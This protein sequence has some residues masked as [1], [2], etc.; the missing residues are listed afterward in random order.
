MNN[1]VT[2]KPPNPPSFVRSLAGLFISKDNPHGITPKE[3]KV[4]DLLYSIVGK[5]K[6]TNK[7]KEIIS[8]KLNQGFQVTVNYVNKLKRKRVITKD[9][10]LHSL[11]FK[12]SITIEHGHKTSN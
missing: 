7:H 11:F 9:G 2:I 5:E 10:R 1:Q 6:I 3:F 12:D 4:L 8:I